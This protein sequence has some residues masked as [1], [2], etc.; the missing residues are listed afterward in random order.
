MAAEHCDTVT[1]TFNGPDKEV[2]CQPDARAR[3]RPGQVK[4]AFDVRPARPLGLVNQGG[5]ELGDNKTAK[6][7][8]HRL[9]MLLAI[10]QSTVRVVRAP[11]GCPAHGHDGLP[12]QELP[13][14][15]PRRRL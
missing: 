6:T 10:R 2:S 11:C 9:E 4:L 3:A 12:V 5:A 8:R 13:C 7:R 1:V 14:N 15:P